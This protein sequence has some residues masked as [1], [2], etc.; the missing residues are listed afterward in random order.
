MPDTNKA[1]G[2]I[3]CLMA[4][5][6]LVWD[7]DPMVAGTCTSGKEWEAWSAGWTEITYSLQTQVS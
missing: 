6:I 7:S 5:K 3:I 2:G 1:N 4:S